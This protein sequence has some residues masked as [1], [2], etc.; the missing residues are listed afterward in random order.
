M[1]R[2]SVSLQVS[3]GIRNVAA[4]LLRCSVLHL[5]QAIKFRMWWLLPTAVFAG[6]LEVFGWSARLWSSFSPELLIPFEMQ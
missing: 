6:I 1:F 4:F 2:F 5:W 3:K